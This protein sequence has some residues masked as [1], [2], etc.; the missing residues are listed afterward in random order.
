MKRRLTFILC[1]LF[2]FLLTPL[3]GSNAAEQRVLEPSHAEAVHLVKGTINEIQSD[4]LFIEVEPG[5]VR[6]IGVQKGERLAGKDL[7]P[8]DRVVLELDVNNLVVDVYKLAE[9][10]V[11]GNE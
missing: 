8:G 1:A 5:I 4:M 10:G 9:P 3:H 7:E 2:I 11:K 6:K